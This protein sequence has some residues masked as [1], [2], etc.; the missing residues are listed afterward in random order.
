[1]K[2]IGGIL[3]IFL[4]FVYTFMWITKIEDHSTYYD[5]E[6]LVSVTP[7]GHR[8]STSYFVVGDKGSTQESGDIQAIGSS[9]CFSKHEDIRV[10]P[11]FTWWQS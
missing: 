2:I 5:C 10:K 8:A 1:M 3:V 9:Y 6:K 11:Y 4:A 7:I